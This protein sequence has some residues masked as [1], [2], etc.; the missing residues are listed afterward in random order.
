MQHSVV[1]YKT[2]GASVEF[3]LHP[4]AAVPGTRRRGKYLVAIVIS[5]SFEY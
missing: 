1:N 2:L 4:E 5:G 3:L